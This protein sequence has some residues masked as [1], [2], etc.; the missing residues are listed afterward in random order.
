VFAA[1]EPGQES[2]GRSPY[3]ETPAAH[4]AADIDSGTPL[5]EALRI[6]LH[7]VCCRPI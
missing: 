6:K 1:V 4:A 2:A 7:S 3:T 5:F